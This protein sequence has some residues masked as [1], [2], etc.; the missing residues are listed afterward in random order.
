MNKERMTTL[1][2]KHRAPSPW[3]RLFFFCFSAISFAAQY[4][5]PCSPSA[6]APLLHCLFPSARFSRCNRG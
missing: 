6:P 2:E 5:R 1:T 4:P 3:T